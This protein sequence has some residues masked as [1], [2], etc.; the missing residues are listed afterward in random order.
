M[1]V[2]WRNLGV[3]RGTPRFDLGVPLV[4]PGV[5]LR[6]VDTRATPVEPRCYM[7]PGHPDNTWGTPCAD[8]GYTRK[9][10]AER[11][12]IGVT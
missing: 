7:P 5:V 10:G 6:L 8:P 2:I 1:V 9:P 3:P 4:A 11:G 12:C